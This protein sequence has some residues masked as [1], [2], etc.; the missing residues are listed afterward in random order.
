MTSCSCTASL[1]RL[2]LVPLVCLLA[3]STLVRLTED[4]LV[5]WAIPEQKTEIYFAMSPGVFSNNNILA[6]SLHTRD[7]TIY[8]ITVG[9]TRAKLD[10]MTITPTGRRSATRGGTKYIVY[11][12]SG[13][14]S[15]WAFVFLNQDVVEYIESSLVTSL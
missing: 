3:C 13:D 14:H 10:S 1:S 6:D 8:L 11:E 15:K 5:G 7:W 4:R 12:Y 9:D 2:L